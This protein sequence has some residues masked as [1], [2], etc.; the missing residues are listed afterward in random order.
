MSGQA[1]VTIGRK[2]WAAHLSTTYAELTTGLKGVAL[3][4]RAT[5]MLFVLPQ[6][7]AVSVTMQGV[8]FP[9]DIIFISA[10]RQVIDVVT[11]ASPGVVLSENTPV[12]YFLEV[13]AGEATGIQMGDTVDMVVTSPQNGAGVSSWVSSAISLATFLISGISMAQM[14]VRVRQ[15]RKKND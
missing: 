4:P 1:I 2:Q 14:L 5:G 8:L 10:Q 11:A 3:L 12:R 15:R 7:Q 6:E 13:N 9:L